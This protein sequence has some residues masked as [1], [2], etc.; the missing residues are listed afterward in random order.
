MKGRIWLIVGV[1][2][3]VAIGIGKLPY[4]DGA[5]SEQCNEYEECAS[6]EP[7]LAADEPVLN[8]EYKLKT[9]KFCAADEA[10][11]IMGARYNLALNGKRYEPCF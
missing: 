9:S 8:A 1:V 6:F 2:V 4:F 11:G 3:G 10:A 7:Y 5:L